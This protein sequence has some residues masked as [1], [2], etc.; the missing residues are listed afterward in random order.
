MKKYWQ[1]SGPNS[2]I[3]RAERSKKQ[4]KHFF[5]V[6]AASFLLKELVSSQTLCFRTI[7]YLLL[8]HFYK[9]CFYLF[10]FY[11][12]CLFLSRFPTFRIYPAK[13]Y[14]HLLILH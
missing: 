13:K 3:W 11:Q 4:L 6:L 12:L 8:L 10:Q 5:G 1:R 2:Q 14:Q 7:F 9:S